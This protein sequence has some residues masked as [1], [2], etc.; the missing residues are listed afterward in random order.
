MIMYL[1][2]TVLAFTAIDVF[3]VPSLRVVEAATVKTISIYEGETYSFKAKQVASNKKNIVSAKKAEIVGK[4]AGKATVTVTKSGFKRLDLTLKTS[5][6]SLIIRSERS[7]F[8]SIS[9]SFKL[10][11]FYGNLKF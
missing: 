3:S 10:P 6:Y 11:V 5:A 1:M 7:I 8:M 9:K 2:I 4:K